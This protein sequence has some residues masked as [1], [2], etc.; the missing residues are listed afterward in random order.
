MGRTEAV[1]TTVKPIRLSYSS[2]KLW[3]E[4]PA[5]WAFR[6]IDK[7][8]EK[9]G[10]AAMRGTRLHTAVERLLKGD[11][12]EASLPIELLKVKPLLMALKAVEAIPEAEWVVGRDWRTDSEPLFKAVV[13]IHYVVGDELH[14]KDLKT[15]EVYDSHVDQLQLYAVMGMHLYPHVQRAH[16]SA[17]YIDHGIEA[18]ECTYER[19]MLADL[20]QLWIDKATAIHSD[21][22]YLPT[23]GRAC[24]FCSFSAKK[25]GPCEAGA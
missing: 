9:A 21:G 13:D 4:C 7:L 20:S 3:Q 23:P 12:T 5:R 22:T 16:V 17:I 8:D 14:I 1:E 10:P 18:K 15:G 6:Y 11:I 2:I 24:R 19:S 25:G